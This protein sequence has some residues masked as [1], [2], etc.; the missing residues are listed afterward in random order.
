VSAASTGCHSL[1]TTSGWIWPAAAI[2]PAGRWHGDITL[3]VAG[4]ALR[5][6][7]LHPDQPM[8]HVL[9]G[10]MPVSWH[11]AAERSWRRSDGQ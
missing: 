1:T 8:S 7:G 2:R 3:H 5:K 6:L 4:E 11:A 10:P 9:A